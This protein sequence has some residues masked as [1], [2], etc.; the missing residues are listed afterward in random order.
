M[1]DRLC[2]FQGDDGEA[3]NDHHGG[4]EAGRASEKNTGNIE[5][6]REKLDRSSRR[7]GEQR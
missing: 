7:E 1:C 2:V 3:L 4:I 5:R 6:E